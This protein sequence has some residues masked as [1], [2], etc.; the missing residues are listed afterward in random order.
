VVDRERVLAKLDQLDGYL[1]ELGQIIPGS[2]AEYRNNFEKR[3]ACERLLQVSIECMIDT[4]GL[5]VS[6]LRL[7]LPSEPDDV[8]EKLDRAKIFSS[9][10]VNMLKAMKGFRNVLVHEY[11]AIDHAIVY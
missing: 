5:F 3:R 11:A 9:S 7:G 6:G 10:V 2:F 1:N 4:C 8:L